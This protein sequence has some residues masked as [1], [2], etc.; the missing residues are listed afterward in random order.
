M[1]LPGFFAEFGAAANLAGSAA[2]FFL[3]T[4]RL[5]VT[6]ELAGFPG[7]LDFSMAGPFLEGCV[8]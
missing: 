1:A 4:G 3:E 7:L 8:N 5:E 6:L 2:C